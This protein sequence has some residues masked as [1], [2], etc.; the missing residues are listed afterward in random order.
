MGKV[1]SKLVPGGTVREQLIE[2]L[3]REIMNYDA[4]FRRDA[5]TGAI[6]SDAR[7]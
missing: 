4:Q 3:T 5:G 2:Q 7:H 6:S 1:T